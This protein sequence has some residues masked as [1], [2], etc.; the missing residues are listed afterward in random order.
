MSLNL[1]RSSGTL[2]SRSAPGLDTFKKKE[3]PM[4]GKEYGLKLHKAI[5]LEYE[6][7]L[8][9]ELNHQEFLLLHRF[10]PTVAYIG[11]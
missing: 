9:Q 10:H 2:R 4:F 11:D 5:C 8:L 1:D 3:N 6:K 7:I